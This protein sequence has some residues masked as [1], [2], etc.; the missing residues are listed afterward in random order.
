MGCR[1]LQCSQRCRANRDDG[2]PRAVRSLDG[3]YR[4]RGQS[5]ALTMH[6][7]LPE[8]FVL[9]GVK[10]SGTHMQ[11]DVG[12]ADASCGKAIKQRLIEMQSGRR[13]GDGAR[14]SRID[15]LVT[16]IVCRLGVPRDVWR[17]RDFAVRFEIVLQRRADREAQPNEAAIAL[18][19]CCACSRGKLDA[20]AGFGW[21]AGAKL[22][23]GFVGTE[24]AFEQQLD[25][26]AARFAT[27]Q[28][29][30]DHASIVEHEEISRLQQF[31]QS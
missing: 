13:S 15:C 26:S 6:P 11:R 4:G 30:A 7:M 20:A 21:M 23:P 31:G 2:V 9:H 5:K 12:E 28:P 10:G 1:G 16:F 29:G 17:Q 22:H 25:D 3:R 24:D 8:I 19:E 27:V 18:D 14:I